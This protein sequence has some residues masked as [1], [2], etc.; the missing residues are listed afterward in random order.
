MAQNQHMPQMPAVRDCMDVYFSTLKPD[1][2][3]FEAVLFLLERR[4]TGSPVVDG[5]GHLLG[6]LTEK[7]CMK[8]LTVG[9]DG[10]VPQG[11]VRD[12]MD[13]DVTTVPPDMDIYYCAGLFLNSE[14]RRFP[15]VYEGKLIG[16]IT[17]FDILR[18][19]RANMPS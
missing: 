10:D 12:Y 17:R 9:R 7:D 6:L 11:T 19:I 13:V 1:T 16:V 15:V 3:I 5:E 4:V 14:Q 8:L 18:A 2:D